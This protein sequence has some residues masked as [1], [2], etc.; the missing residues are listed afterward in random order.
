MLVLP[1]ADVWNWP[2]TLLD[3]WNAAAAKVLAGTASQDDVDG[4]ARAIRAAGHPVR[5]GNT[6]HE[7][8]QTKMMQTM[9]TASLTSK[10]PMTA[11]GAEVPATPAAVGTV[12][13]ARAAPAAPNAA[14]GTDGNFSTDLAALIATRTHLVSELREELGGLQRRLEAAER[15][16]VA[17]LAAQRAYE[18]AWEPYRQGETPALA[19][20]A[21]ELSALAASDRATEV[22]ER[23]REAGAAQT[24]D[25]RTVRTRR[26]SFGEPPARQ[27]VRDWAATHGGEV[28]VREVAQATGRNH[29]TIGSAF[30]G[31]YGLVEK[32]EFER[33]AV[34][35]YRRVVRKEPD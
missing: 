24:A 31:H 11:A 26:L 3:T 30:L 20:V 2:S 14:R 27:L 16:L 21:A 29:S 10:G 17:L 9:Q 1:E 13:P 35:H 23:A 5:Y 18:D 8:G 19:A 34:N 4:V 33:V 15:D 12:L 28:H 22:T 7:K 25:R 32:G 6:E